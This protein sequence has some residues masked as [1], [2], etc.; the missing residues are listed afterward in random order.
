MLIGLLSSEIILLPEPRPVL[1]R[2]RMTHDPGE[3]HVDLL[4]VWACRRGG[5]PGDQRK[6]QRGVAGGA[7]RRKPGVVAGKGDCGRELVVSRVTLG[8]CDACVG[9]LSGVKVPAQQRELGDVNPADVTICIIERY[10][11]R[12]I[13]HSVRSPV[14]ARQGQHG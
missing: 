9:P 7:R 12:F 10:L 11:Q 5:I 6:I 8:D 4:C 13:Q 14:L 2:L 3:E 1:A